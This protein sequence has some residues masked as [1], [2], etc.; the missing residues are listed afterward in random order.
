MVARTRLHVTL[1]YSGCLA[2]RYQ[3]SY[4][5]SLI[6]AKRKKKS[7]NLLLHVLFTF[8]L[9]GINPNPPTFF[10]KEI[11]QHMLLNFVQLCS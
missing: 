11:T 7:L 9:E 2:Y 5:M 10:L 6:K 1:Q 8:H 4:I 3:N